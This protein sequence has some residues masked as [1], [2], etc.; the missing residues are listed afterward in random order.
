MDVPKPG[1]CCT[2]IYTSG[3]TGPPKAVMLSHDNVTWTTTRMAEDYSLDLNHT[4]RLLSFLPLSHIAAQLIDIHIPITLGAATYFAQP[5]ALKGSLVNSIKDIQPTVFFGVP[6][7]W[8]KIQEKMVQVGRG[9]GGVKKMIATWA[10][11]VG[12][13]KNKLAQ[14]G[15]AGGV[16]FGYACANKIVFATIKKTLGFD[17]CRGF[18][19]AAAPI[20]VD[21]LNYF[22]S[23]DIPLYE[24]FGQ[25]ECTGP[26]TVSSYG[27][28]KIGACGRPLY[29]TQS[30]IDSET[31]ELCYR[32][33][34][35]FMGYM[36]MPKETAATIDNEGYLHS[37]D[38]AEF[39]SDDSAYSPSPSGFMKI[40]G[41]IKDLIITAG[42]ENVPPILIENEMKAAMV[43]LSN[44]MVV[45]DKRKYLAMVVSL[46]TEVDPVTNAPTDV[47]AADSLF[48]ARQIGSSALTV[49]EA[50]ADPL[51]NAYFDDGLKKGNAMSTSTAQIVQKWKLLP[52]DFSEAAGDLTPTMKVK[53][54]VLLK[55]YAQVID[56]IYA[57]DEDSVSV[58]SHV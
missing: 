34:H 48:V 12:T 15:K 17:K 25:S 9:N 20:S 58:V 46:K 38:V 27:N 56:S 19:T 16:P 43:A 23:L 6:R 41:R 30:K 47:L 7:V 35:I 10:K 29:G 52:V 57:A 5:D 8:E 3:T 26:H 45:G 4:D 39:D 49:K 21:T 55:K 42:G 53:R 36:Y 33:R 37:G 54:N 24:V 13:E 51:W 1:H 18:F 11:G 14:Y 44:C 2:L 28:W 40:T 50:L 22:A 32:G 31:G